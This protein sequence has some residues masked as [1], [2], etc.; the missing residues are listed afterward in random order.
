VPTIDL[1]DGALTGPAQETA[2]ARA[3]ITVVLVV[4]DD[5]E[6]CALTWPAQETPAARAA[7]TVVLVVVDDC[8]LVLVVMDDCEPHPAPAS[9]SAVAPTATENFSINPSFPPNRY[10]TNNGSRSDDLLPERPSA[11][12]SAPVTTSCPFP[13]SHRSIEAL[14][15]SE[16]NRFV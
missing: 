12:R 4:V 13:H 10:R 14:S 16:P 2:A 1:A 3:A 7:I 9:A 6:L 11:I 15:Q 8:E 5:C